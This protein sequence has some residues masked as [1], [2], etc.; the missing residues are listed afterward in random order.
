MDRMYKFFRKGSSEI[1]SF[2]FAVVLLFTILISIVS[3]MQIGMV[4]ETMTYAVYAAGRAAV[5]SP[6]EN[7]AKARAQMVAEESLA[8]RIGNISPDDI[9]TKLEIV[10]G[11]GWQKGSYAKIT[12][13]VKLNTF[14]NYFSSEGEKSIVMLVEKGGE[15]DI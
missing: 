13:S 14:A 15:D 12:L 2:L 3:I 10:E 5:I 7:N 1:I 8:D 9:Y 4:S 6:D 11:D